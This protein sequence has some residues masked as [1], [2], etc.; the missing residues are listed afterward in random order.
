MNV[1]RTPARGQNIAKTKIPTNGP[2]S[3]PI[4]LTH[5][6]NLFWFQFLLQKTGTFIHF[7]SS[8]ITIV[9]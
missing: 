6:C 4:T 2:E 3:A 9:M 5:T 8:S 1:E 7:H